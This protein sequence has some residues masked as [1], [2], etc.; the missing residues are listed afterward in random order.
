MIVARFG[1]PPVVINVTNKHICQKFLSQTGRHRSA[2]HRISRLYE[3]PLPPT[4]SQCCRQRRAGSALTL[5]A[6]LE[7]DRVRS[8]RVPRESPAAGPSRAVTQRNPRLRYERELLLTPTV[9]K[10][11]RQGRSQDFPR[12]GGLSLGPG[13]TPPKTQKSLDCF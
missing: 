13:S 3:C 7:A 2:V 11:L 5:S 9:L 4:S 12:G 8:G 1:H 10:R 6:G